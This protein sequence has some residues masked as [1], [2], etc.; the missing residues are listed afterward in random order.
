MRCQK[1]RRRP[2]SHLV[3]GIFSRAS[4]DT[5]DL[6]RFYTKCLLHA[7]LR[8]FPEWIKSE[9]SVM[10]TRTLTKHERQVAAIVEQTLNEMIETRLT[11]AEIMDAA[12]ASAQR[13][14]N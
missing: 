6:S 12:A 13:S 1:G 2:Y 11:V 7:E 4:C 14:R 3:A 9:V 5:E 8:N 10:A